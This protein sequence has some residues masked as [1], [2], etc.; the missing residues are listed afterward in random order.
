M[1][2]WMLP[3]TLQFKTFQVSDQS[4]SFFY[5]FIFF[6]YYFLL[7]SHYTTHSTVVYL[8]WLLDLDHVNIVKKSKK[9]IRTI[10]WCYGI[11]SYLIMRPSAKSSSAICVHFRTNALAKGKSLFLIHRHGLRLDLAVRVRAMD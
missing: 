4:S 9:R 3:K 10:D 5:I 2:S 6:T 1:L 11:V 8:D 7:I